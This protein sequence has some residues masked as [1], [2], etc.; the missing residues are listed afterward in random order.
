MEKVTIE[1]IT[2]DDYFVS[3]GRS[4]NLQDADKILD[5]HQAKCASCGMEF[6][7]KALIAFL[8]HQSTKKMMP[9]SDIISLSSAAGS[10][11]LS[12][13]KCPNCGHTKMTIEI[14]EIKSQSKT[15][16]CF[17]ATATFGSYDH[18]KVVIFRRFR[19]SMLEPYFLGKICISLYY[20]ISPF[21]AQIIIKYPLIRNPL[22]KVLIGFAE[23]IETKL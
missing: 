1:I 22:K 20:K 21:F 3:L 4:K 7:R 14:N 23:F 17:I 11:A 19:D 5:L 10:G 6:Y 2:Y 16:F 12:E 18:P 8:N 15:K 13:G 9:G